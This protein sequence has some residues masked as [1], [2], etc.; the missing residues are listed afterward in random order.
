MINYF[1]NLT[2]IEII[3][4]AIGFLGQGLF[5]LHQSNSIIRV[6]V[7]SGSGRGPQVGIKLLSPV[8]DPV[9]ITVKLSKELGV[10]IEVL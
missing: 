8:K 7:R 6:L 9:A 10:P 3:F 2:N 4:L 1:N 5:A